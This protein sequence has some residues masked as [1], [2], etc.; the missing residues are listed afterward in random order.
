MRN[1]I[2]SCCNIFCLIEGVKVCLCDMWADRVPC[3]AFRLRMKRFFYAAV[4]HNA[5]EHVR[6]SRPVYEL[7]KHILQP[8]PNY[9]LSTADTVSMVYTKKIVANEILFF[10]NLNFKV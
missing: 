9:T 10:E 4:C 1:S 6:S 7:M 2:V 3:R 5:V 8:A